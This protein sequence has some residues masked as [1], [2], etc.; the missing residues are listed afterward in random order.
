MSGGLSYKI[1]GLAAL[2]ALLCAMT[3]S[4]ANVAFGDQISVAGSTTVKPIIDKAAEEYQKSHPGTQFAVGAGGSGQGIALAGKGE[5]QIGMSSRPLKDKEES[6]Y[7]NLTSV[8]LG[9]DG[10]AI[11]VHGDNPVKQ[12]TTQQVVDI[13]TGKI[14]NWKELGGQDAAIV[15]IS[16][17]RKHGTFDGFAEHFKLEANS[18][19][20]DAGPP[21][22]FKTKEAAEFPKTGART[23]D[24]NKAALAAVLTQ[25][26]GIAFASFGSTQALA[27]KGSPIKMLDLD[28]V[29]PTEANVVDG[30]YSFQRSLFVL[31]NGAPTGEVEN[32]IKFLTSKEGQTIVNSLDYISTPAPVQ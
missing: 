2:S 13:Y 11:V 20:A 15:L 5:V 9:L 28:G 25:P 14:T 29:A 19:G 26:N 3:F 17:N 7:P 16:L 12:I 30:K 22:F 10:I 18:E 8:K 6:E 1:A 24:G 4:Q 31:T 23:V 21:V 32:F 27:A